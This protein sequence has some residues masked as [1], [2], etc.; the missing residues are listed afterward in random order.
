MPLPSKSKPTH[1][2]EIILPHQPQQLTG[3][4]WPKHT[5]STVRRRLQMTASLF[6]TNP[7]RSLCF[8]TFEGGFFDDAQRH[9]RVDPRACLCW[10]PVLGSSE[11]KPRWPS[12]NTPP[13]V[14]E[15]TASIKSKVLLPC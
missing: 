4:T 13:T 3:W 15:A 6:A 9:P 14:F 7:N 10:E 8:W 1:S 11:C 5:A 12:N 2:C